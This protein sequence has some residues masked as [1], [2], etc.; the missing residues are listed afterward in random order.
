MRRT[1]E[2]TVLIDDDAATRWLRRVNVWL[3]PTNGNPVCFAARTDLKKLSARMVAAGATP[4][5]I[6]V[7]A[8]ALLEQRGLLH[9]VAHLDARPAGRAA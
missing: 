3:V 2:P 4:A 1:A 7:E 5:E 9:F 8:R 6:A